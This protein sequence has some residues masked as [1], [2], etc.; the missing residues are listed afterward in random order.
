M[1]EPP[2]YFRLPPSPVIFANIYRFR[3]WAELVDYWM[4]VGTNVGLYES[5]IYNVIQIISLYILLI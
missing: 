4:L 3:L 5:L 1:V 2:N